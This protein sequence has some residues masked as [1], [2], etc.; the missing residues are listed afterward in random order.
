M[1]N[2][3]Q[4]EQATIDF[5]IVF[6]FSGVMHSGKDT[7]AKMMFDELQKQGKKV[8]YVNYADFLKVVCKRNFGYDDNNK[9]EDRHIL[10]D[11][12]TYV[13]SIDERF[14]VDTVCHLFDVL[15]H[16]YDAF[17]IG[18]VRYE[19]E[20]KPYPYRLS[21]PFFN[22]YVNRDLDESIDQQ[23]LSHESEEMNLKPDLETFHFIVD[24]N[25]TLTE[26]EEQIKQI[27]ELCFEYK[28]KFLDQ[29]RG[30]TDEQLQD[31]LEQQ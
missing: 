4:S 3:T 25:G 18:D 29:Q 6:T 8:L 22:I 11:F 2:N 13:R 12:G 17:I 28:Q 9:D 21:Y 24:N 1:T 7:C 20:M 23:S 30:I 19:N 15:R 31:I 26:T 27:I 14:W 5:P 16:E 10:Q